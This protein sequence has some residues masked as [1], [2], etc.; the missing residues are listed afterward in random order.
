VASTYS[1]LKIELIGTGEQSGTWGSTTNNNLGTALEEAIVGLAVANFPTNADLTLTLTNTNATQIARHFVLRA[2][3]SVSLTV[4]RNL[5]VPAIEKP[6]LI[7]NSTT[8]GQSIIVKNTTGA[9]VTVPNGAE[10]FVYNDGTNVVSAIDHIPSLTLGTA[11]SPSSGGTGLSSVGTSGNVLTS[12]GTVWTSVAPAA[13]TRFSAGTTGFTPNTLSSGDV[14]LAGTL[15]AANGGT[16]R[17]TLTANNLLAG[18]GT[19]IVNLIAPGA[20]G[21]ILTSNGTSWTSAAAPTGITTTTGNPAYYAA[22]AWVNFNGTG[23]VSIRAQANVS[24]IT[25]NGIGIYTVNFS[26]AMPDANYSVVFGQASSDFTFGKSMVMCL[27]ATQSAAGTLPATG[28]VRVTSIRSASAGTDA[29]I[30]DSAYC[31]VSIFR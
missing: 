29:S 9:G 12:D 10:V 30:E 17:N 21:Q 27:S 16:G 11:L 13:G 18:N 4:T 22:R 19:G 7:Q 23:T 20:N 14:T 26:T 2:T 15:V 3:S 1:A 28:S 6:Y 24:S 31:L 5:I 25:D 8:G